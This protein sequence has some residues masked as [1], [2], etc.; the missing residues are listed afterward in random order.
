LSS[1]TGELSREGGAIVDPA[2]ESESSPA[3]RQQHPAVAR[4]R[5]LVVSTVWDTE[6][7]GVT[8]DLWNSGGVL[9]DG[10]SPA[11]SGRG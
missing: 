4:R 10:G 11:R 9:G 3:L 7:P 2:V 8:F 1:G 5:A 6:R